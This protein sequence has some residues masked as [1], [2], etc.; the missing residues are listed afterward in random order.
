MAVPTLEGK[1]PPADVNGKD[2]NGQTPLMSAANAA[3][4]D[5]SD[6]V[7]GLLEAGADTGVQDMDGKTPLILAVEEGHTWSAERLLEE[8]ADP[9]LKDKD[10]KTAFMLAAG[11]PETEKALRA[12][13]AAREPQT[14]TET[15]TA[16]EPGA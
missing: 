9:H 11:H 4:K 2:E 6:A 1:H 14:D 16:P 8:G 7:K 5:D 15:D 12:A 13:A 3:K 10:G